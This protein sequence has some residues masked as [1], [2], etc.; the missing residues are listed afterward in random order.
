MQKRRKS[1]RLLVQKGCHQF[2]RY[3]LPNFSMMM[4]SGKIAFQNWLRKKITII[5]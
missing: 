1:L 4:I 2:L 3:R 5:S